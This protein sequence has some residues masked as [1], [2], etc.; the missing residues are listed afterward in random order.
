MEPAVKRQSL[1]PIYAVM[2]DD[3]EKVREL[4]SPI[5]VEEG[6]ELVDAEITHDMGSKILRIYIDKDGGVTVGD[7]TRVSHAVEDL[8]EVEGVV[9]GRYNLEISSP[10]LNR[11]LRRKEHFLKVVG[12]IVDLTTKEKLDGRKNYRGLLKSMDNDV[13]VMEIDHQEF[14]VPLEKLAK[15]KLVFGDFMVD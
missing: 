3:L 10:G 8:L 14:H 7:C 6:C 5:I 15:A 1:R 4:V 2:S 13:L 9:S 11:P 12:Q